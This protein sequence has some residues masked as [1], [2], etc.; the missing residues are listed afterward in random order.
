MKQKSLSKKLTKLTDKNILSYQKHL[1]E[2]LK[3]SPATVKRRLSSIRKF[4]DWALQENYLEKNPF[5]KEAEIPGKFIPQKLTPKANVFQK[6]Y[7]TYSQFS[8]TKYFHYAILII[9]CAAIG[10]GA[11]DQFFK[12][13]PTPLAYPESLTA[14]NRFLSF[15]GRLTDSSDN[16]I[17]GYT[18][19]TFKLWKTSSG[20]TEGTCTG[21]TGEDCLWTSGTCSVNSDQDGIFSL[22][23]G[24]TSGP[25]YTCS[26]AIEIPAD[27]FSENT[28]IWLA[29]TVDDDGEMDPRMQVATVGYALNAETLQG[30]PP[31]TE[32]SMI[33]YI[34]STGKVVLAAASPTIQATS[35]TF[36][37]EGQTGITI[38]VAD[39]Q[40]GNITLSPKG[41]GTVNLTSEAT[42]GNLLNNQGGANFGTEGGKEDNNLYY[43]YVGL[44]TT[45]FNLLKLEAGETPSAKFTIDASG[46]ASAA[47]I[48]K[49]R[50]TGSYLT[51]DITVSG[52]GITGANSVVLDIGEASA[53]YITSSVGLAVGGAQTYYINT[54]TSNLNAL[55]LAGNLTV[56]TDD[57]FVNA[58]ENKIGIGTTTL[59]ERLTLAGNATISGTLAL[60]PNVQFD[61][62]TCDAAAAGKMYYDG[63]NNKYYFCNGTAW[64][65]MGSGSGGGD[66][67]WTEALGLLY[68]VNETLDLAV[69]GTATDS[70]NV[71]LGASS[72]SDSFIYGGS[73]GIGTRE[74]GAE[75][76]VVGNILVQE[77]GTIDTR[78]AGTLT[79]GGTTQTGLTLGRADQSTTL[80]GNVQAFTLAGNITGSGTPNITGI[81]SFSGSSATLSS[82]GDALTLSGAGANINFSGA[83]L[84]QI[85]TGVSQ[86]LALMPG[87]NVG[88]G[89]TSP[90]DLLEIQGAEGT[91]AI[92][93]L[94]ADEGD[95]AA[96]TWEIRS[97]AADN[98]LSFVNDTTEV[99]NLTSGGNLQI[100]GDLAI[101]GGN[102]T[103]AVTADSTLTVTGTLTA[104]SAFTLGDG[105][106]TGSINTSSWDVSTDGAASG[107][108][109]ISSSG[110]IDLSSLSAGGLVKA[111]VTTG[112]LSIA[113]GGTDYEYPLTFSN[114]LTRTDN[115][116]KLGGA[117][118]EST[119]ITQGNYDMIFNLSDTGDFR[120]QDDGTDVLFVKDDG[121]VGI[122]NNNPGAKLH[123]VGTT[124]LG[125]GLTGSEDALYVNTGAAFSGNLLKLAVNGSQKLAIDSTGMLTTAS[126]VFTSTVADAADAIGFKLITPEYTTSGAKLLSVWNNTDEKMSLDKDGILALYNSES[127]IYNASGDIT[128]DAASG[129]VSFATNNLI[130]IDDLTMGGTAS[131]SGTPNISLIPTTGFSKIYL[132]DG[133]DLS[134][135]TSVGGDAEVTERIRLTNAGNL[136]PGADDSYDLGSDSLRW[137]NLYLAS[138]TLHLGSSS[139]DEGTFSYNTSSNL[140]AI[141]STG[142]IALKGITIDGDN[143]IHAAR[144][145]DTAGGGDYFV[146]PAAAG[147]A[148]SFYGNV[149]INNTSPTYNLD[150][151]GDI[152]FTGRFLEDGSEIL[153][154][155]ITAFTGS[156]PT[157]W[158]EYTAARGRTIVGTPSGGTGEGTVG[159]ALTDLGT[160]TI[161]DVPAH[162]HTYYRSPR[163]GDECPDN[164]GPHD[165]IGDNPDYLAD[166]GSTGVAS[167][168]VTMPYIQLT[169]CQKNAGAD[170]AEWIPA[171]ENISSATIVSVDPN[172]REKVIIS[173]RAYDPTVIGIIA[174]QP[175]WLIGEEG[176]NSV[177]MALAGRV[178]TKVSLINGEIKP[179]DPITTSSIPG[180]GMKATKN[181]PIIGKAMDAL[182][183]TSSL[184]NC[185]NPET[186]RNEKCGTILTFVN[187]S[188]FSPENSQYQE[189]TLLAQASNN[190]Y[191][192]L[193][194]GSDLT[195]GDLVTLIYEQV[196]SQEDSNKLETITTISKTQP[197]IIN[198]NSF[199]GVISTNIG[200]KGD[201]LRRERANNQIVSETRLIFSGIADV[202]ISSSSQTIKSGDYLALSGIDNGMATKATKVG[203]IIG[204]ALE[205]WSPDSEK[206]TIRVLVGS[207]WYDPDIY[208]TSTG[209]LNITNENQTA[210]GYQ[211][212]DAAGQ[213]I[214]RIGVFTEIAVAKIKAGLINTQELI[215]EKQIISPLIE[216]EEINTQRISLAEINSSTEDG[217]I[218]INLE[219]QNSSESA[220]GKL[221][222]KGEEGE[223]VASI[224]A[225][226]NAS[227]SGQVNAEN[228][229]IEKDATITGTLYADEIITKHGKFG[230][231]LVGTMSANY[232]TQNI[233]NVY[234]NE[235]SESS[236][237]MA[238]DS[239]N[240]FDEF[241]DI[242]ALI[243]EILNTPI[244]DGEEDLD[245]DED[246][247]LPSDS[248]TFEGDLLVLGTTSLSNVT[249]TESLNIG[250][251]LS[252]ADNTINT[253]SGPLYLQSLGLGGIDILAGKIVIDEHGNATFEGDVTIKGKLAT[254]S[255]NPLPENDLVIDLAQIPLTSESEEENLETSQ[256]AFGKLLVKGFEGQT[257][258]S[259]DA[260]GSAYFTSLGLEADYSATESGMIIAAY[261]NWLENNEYS[262]AIK[263]NASTGVAILPAYEQ[264]IM[265]Y[266]PK[267]TDKSLVYIT[268]VTDTE[269]KVVYV[270]AKKSQKE[271]EI[272]EEGYEINPEEKGWFKVAIDTPIN[273]DIQFNW[274][275]I[276]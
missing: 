37:L 25:E 114:G 120:V 176:N 161:T 209:E 4:C 147:T 103:T 166:T 227:F 203:Q 240:L 193:R 131:I 268:P 7:Q 68:P 135:Y 134:F 129:N 57:F 181:G 33:P 215:A 63:D 258:A 140:L 130:N 88:I 52:G 23:L 93:T 104:N 260:S 84:A 115:A 14:P 200:G 241:D 123:V 67:W 231:L 116:V 212:K 61:A 218:T 237:L 208:L 157:G 79:I 36:A 47:G 155:M 273:K 165:I 3:L 247:D 22:L 107:F 265:I 58:S 122:G 190:Y 225:K 12:K 233:T 1:V 90:E 133:G 21:D 270:K 97:E 162:T 78:A 207:D 178:P 214:E 128:I 30:Y 172:N 9:F 10:F 229:E 182:N 127:M 41:T 86:D 211:L 222:I 6:A 132:L 13:T 66:S 230:D 185:L 158:T 177:Q 109:G 102:I 27:V 235:A 196:P 170:L 221:I 51:G 77:E 110:D 179:G 160:R 87:G 272:D 40:D 106:D 232:I 95:D 197:L 92:L 274:W 248:Y 154:G 204:R 174:T 191:E 118:T 173:K 255:I 159:T 198:S 53:D 226:G 213:I 257:V 43:G 206:E 205:S 91:D 219:S 228:L 199:A 19:I 250:G 89:T 75:L 252:L 50:T 101:S 69:G 64:T 119:T 11:Y 76:D 223:E 150:V 72:D 31:G 29:I 85:L 94:D 269:N 32:A 201:L 48:L 35:G 17:S 168:D 249:I 234:Q 151:T 175:G 73:L 148:G 242:E 192:L 189:D 5:L 42:T 28:D 224:D 149:G 256:S 44:D 98:D 56:D 267:I 24:T 243:A 220:L 164:G 141:D 254:K 80:A 15:Q 8:V 74:P 45:N 46:N 259:I 136:V 126:G 54:G 113:T 18:D 99:M 194:F 145:V 117:L 187:I 156:C 262:P 125:G 271:T 20:G 246:I 217:N 239:A 171:S 183:E 38:Q 96:D 266:N 276:N 264:E 65:E 81:G 49:A 253:F 26:A 153:S 184:N 83:G 146:D 70:A 275:I 59:T 144:F 188:W 100:D 139:G 142:N 167:V 124:I 138:E 39:G 112:R 216:S 180:V 55:A 202:K 169:Y 62:G 210:D 143:F 251:T 152:N 121:N 105:G 2:E 261:D 195:D 244:N 245:L 236:D 82:T 137:A 16:P 60:A 163:D 34:D 263:T 108:T 238:T 186:G 71:K 111:A